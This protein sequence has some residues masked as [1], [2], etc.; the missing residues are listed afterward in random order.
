MKAYN[1]VLARAH[2]RERLIV[3]VI[4]SGEYSYGN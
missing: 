1:S 4:V 2:K 3:S